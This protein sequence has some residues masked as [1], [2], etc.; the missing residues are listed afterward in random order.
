MQPNDM[1]EAAEQRRE[2]DAEMRHEIE[3]GMHEIGPGTTLVITYRIDDEL[4]DD[5]DLE[6]IAEEM[7][8]GMDRVAYWGDIIEVK[9]ING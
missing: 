5:A 9:K 1:E 3:S 4:S 8:C 7:L 6:E 2:D